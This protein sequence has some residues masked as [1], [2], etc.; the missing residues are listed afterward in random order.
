MIKMKALQSI[1]VL[2]TMVGIKNTTILIVEGC[3]EAGIVHFP[4]TTK[5]TAN[6]I[7]NLVGDDLELDF[8]GSGTSHE[9][10]VI[11]AW[12][13][14]GSREVSIFIL[15]DLNI[16]F[17][18]HVLIKWH[19]FVYKYLLIIFFPYS[20]KRMLKNTMG[21]LKQPL[22][23]PVPELHVHLLDTQLIL[24]KCP[25]VFLK[26]SMLWQNLVGPILNP[27]NRS[28]KKYNETHMAN[29]NNVEKCIGVTYVNN[30]N[31]QS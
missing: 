23:G 2:E 12:R 25:V 3:I 27:Q 30:G 5:S 14:W 9:I 1:D 10:K 21:C 29:R 6:L 31:E 24:L 20:I 11:A 22:A 7:I 28:E 26:K 8:R 13:W 17:V 19:V 18:Q 16:L 4:W 15:H